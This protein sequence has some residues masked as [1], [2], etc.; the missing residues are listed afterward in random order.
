MAEGVYEEHGEPASPS[1]EDDEGEVAARS[2]PVGATGGKP[3]IGHNSVIGLDGALRRWHAFSS[4]VPCAGTLERCTPLR[5]CS[6]FSLNKHGV[7]EQG[8]SA[9]HGV[10]DF[11]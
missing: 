1:V 8:R 7:E 3:L 4:A 2:P 10:D 6:L 11:C 5:C 9:V